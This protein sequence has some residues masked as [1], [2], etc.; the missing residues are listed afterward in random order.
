MLVREAD[1][2]LR[3]IDKVAKLYE[4]WRQAGK[5]QHQAKTMIG[6]RVLGMCTGDEDL[7]DFD[8]L[9]NDLLWQTACEVDAPFAG[10]STLCRFEN[11]A[12]R[13]LAVGVYEILVETFIASFKKP[14][15]EIILDLGSCGHVALLAR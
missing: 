12:D 1:R 15:E 10:K 4:D 13:K 11:K 14:P 6:Q 7:N 8:E 2:K 3:L 9:R 5:V